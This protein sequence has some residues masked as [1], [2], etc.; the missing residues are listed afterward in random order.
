VTV[1]ADQFR[2]VV[3]H[4]ENSKTIDE[5]HAT[6]RRI[7]IASLDFF[8]NGHGNDQFESLCRGLPPLMGRLLIPGEDLV[9]AGIRGKVA[10]DRGFEVDGRH[11][12]ET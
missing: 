12:Y 1:L 4:V 5:F 9:A 10:G 3:G 11:C 2:D 7:W 6:P 8:E